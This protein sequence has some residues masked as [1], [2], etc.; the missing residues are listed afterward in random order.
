MKNRVLSLLVCFIFCAAPKLLFAQTFNVK[1][2]VSVTVS[3][4]APESV[5]SFIT[6]NQN[7]PLVLKWSVTA[8]DFPASWLTAM[9]L[10]ICDNNLCYPNMAPNWLWG[11][12]GGST[13][14]SKPYGDTTTHGDF[15]LALVFESAVPGTHYLTVTLTDSAVATSTKTTT[16]IVNKF[17]TAVP[18]VKSAINEVSIYPNPATSALNVVYDANADVKTIALYSI[19]GKLITV[20]K[21]SENN[22]ANLN[23]ENTPTGIYFV[24]LMN[25]HGDIVA[26]KRFTKQ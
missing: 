9:A 17:P 12:F 11:S 21:V 22:G 6:N 24:R 4:G 20:Y 15:H 10:G 8:T 7:G 26:T 18:A 25:S 5:Y 2:T 23:L 14:K 3:G 19:I 13:F 1:D 16:F